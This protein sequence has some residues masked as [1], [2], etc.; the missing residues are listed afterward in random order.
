MAV[1][2]AANVEASDKAGVVLP[3]VESHDGA[4]GTELEVTVRDD[5][6]EGHAKTSV[7]GKEALGASSRLLRQTNKPSKVLFP[8]PTSKARRLQA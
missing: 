2:A 1:C 6:S 7:E 3:R 8:E 5:S 4:E